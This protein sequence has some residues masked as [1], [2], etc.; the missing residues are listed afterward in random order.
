MERNFYKHKK[1][2]NTYSLIG[3]AKVQCDV[4]LTDLDNV[5]IYK[6]ENNKFWIRPVSEF[7]ERFEIVNA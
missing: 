6:D 3:E 4:P 1:T 2:G 5:Y 7:N